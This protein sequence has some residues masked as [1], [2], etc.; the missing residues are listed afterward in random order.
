M[1]T[2]IIEQIG[3][4]ESIIGSLEKRLCIHTPKRMENITQGESISLDGICLTVESFTDTNF[5]CYASAHTVQTT[6]LSSL[7]VG[8]HVNLE[9]AL[10]PTTRLGGHFV[11]G[12]ID[13]TVRLI[14]KKDRGDSITLSFKIP[15]HI[16]HYIV[17]KGSIALQGISLT[18]SSLTNEYC[19]L[20][21]IPETQK[22]STVQYWKIGDVL[23]LEVDILAKYIERSI[24]QRSHGITE[25]FLQ[26]HGFWK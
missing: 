6:T 13:T 4:V 22:A 2:G 21:I 15:E 23:N 20:T 11:T 1:F 7:Q 5:T 26:E 16:Q 3:R 17:A 14:Q 12:H 19:E 24:N 18:V 25:N 10:L 8:S 9:R